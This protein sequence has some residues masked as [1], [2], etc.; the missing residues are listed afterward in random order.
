MSLFVHSANHIC[1][2][3]TF[4][5]PQSISVV[6][7]NRIVPILILWGR[8]NT[9]TWEELI[10]VVDNL[11]T[12]LRTSEVAIV[13]KEYEKCISQ[14]C[15]LQTFIIFLSLLYL[16]PCTDKINIFIWCVEC[17]YLLKINETQNILQ[18]LE[19]IFSV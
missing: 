12:A 5:I 2:S 15:T 19:N 14:L 3:L 8:V 18:T 16:F 1:C 7:F 9:P 11:Y 10:N 17:S 4:L 13:L 6:S